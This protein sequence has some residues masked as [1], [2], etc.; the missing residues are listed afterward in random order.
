MLAIFLEATSYFNGERGRIVLTS[1]TPWCVDVALGSTF[2]ILVL[3]GI[4]P[5]S[6]SI[7]VGLRSRASTFL[8]QGF[9]HALFVGLVGV[10]H[11]GHVGILRWL[12]QQ[13]E[14]FA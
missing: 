10:V 12:P 5:T 8:A 6:T 14:G 4:D 3:I 9:E 1:L 2:W 7:F 11:L 13:R